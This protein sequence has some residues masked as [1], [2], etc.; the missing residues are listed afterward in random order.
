MPLPVVFDTEDVELLGRYIAEY[1]DEDQTVWRKP[2]EGPLGASWFIHELVELRA[3]LESGIEIADHLARAEV[4]PRV[5]GQGLLA[6]H[7]YLYRLARRMGYTIREMGS[8]IRYNPTV[9]KRQ[10]F[11]DWV[12]ALEVNPR[13]RFDATDQAVIEQFVE[14]LL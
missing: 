2:Q 12:Q 5:H 14:A 10:N 8:L 7:D 1:D 9:S 6:E 13:L 11:L 4:F 3:I